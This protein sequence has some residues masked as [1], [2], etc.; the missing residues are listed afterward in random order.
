M[1]EAGYGYEEI[2]QYYY[3]GIELKEAY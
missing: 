3:Q 2:L 1:A